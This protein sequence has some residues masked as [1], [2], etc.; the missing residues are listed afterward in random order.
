[1]NKRTFKTL[2]IVSFLLLFPATALGYDQEYTN[3]F[4]AS[5]GGTDQSTLCALASKRA[6]ASATL[7]NCEYKFS[8]PKGHG[9]RF[10]QK[11]IFNLQCV[12]GVCICTDKLDVYCR[13]KE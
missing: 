3:S 7:D 6:A 10:G 2:S 5:A 1:M 13:A 11:E 9:V 12:D 4:E 8:S